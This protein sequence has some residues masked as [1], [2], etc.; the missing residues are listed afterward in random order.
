MNPDVLVAIITVVG[1]VSVATI[2]LLV[3]I[4]KSGNQVDH[5]IKNGLST[6]VKEIHSD[7]QLT[8][9]PTL[10]ELKA[11]KDGFDH[12]PLAS[13]EEVDKFIGSVGSV[14]DAI[15]RIQRDLWVVQRA[16]KD[17][18]DWEEEQKY[19]EIEQYME[20]LLLKLVERRNADSGQL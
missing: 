20:S 5:T 14:E 16:L 1:S 3:Q 12:T 19:S 18:I 17:Y 4:R 7:M 15:A 8:V 6:A 11:W 10:V 2:G 9:L 13:R